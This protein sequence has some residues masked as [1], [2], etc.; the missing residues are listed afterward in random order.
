MIQE[1]RPRLPGQRLA[2]GVCRHLMTHD[3]VTIEEF[4][5]ERG[6]R[7]D[8]M[9][10]GP[11]AEIWVIECKSSRADFMSDGKWPGYLDWCDRYFWAVDAGFPTDL[12]PEGTGLII[13]DDYDAEILRMAPE[14]RLAPARRTALVRRFARDAARRLRQFTDPGS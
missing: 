7:V 3:F 14:N 4:I 5:P 2:R 8:V 1:S 6:R 11:R 10:L 13:A 9:A 12:L